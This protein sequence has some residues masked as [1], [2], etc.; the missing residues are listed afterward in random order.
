M[1]LGGFGGAPKFPRSVAYNY[2]FRYF[3]RT[4]NEEASDMVLATLREMAKGGMHDQ[5]G[6]GFHRYSVDARWFVPHFE[7][8]LYDQAQL[9]VSYLEAYQIRASGNMPMLPATSSSTFF[10]TCSIRAEDSIPRRMRT[11]SSIP[12]IR[13]RRVRERFMCGRMSN[14]RVC[15]AALSRVGFRFAT[16]WKRMAMCGKTRRRSLPEKTFSYQKHSIAETAAKFG[17]PEE[18]VR[19]ALDGAIAKLLKSRGKRVR[20][21]LDDKILTAWNG[22]MISAL[23]KGAA[24]LGEPRYFQA[25][26]NAERSCGNRCIGGGFC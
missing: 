20:P 22:L 6:G 5:L 26:R 1:K 9:A 3:Y 16:A 24:V 11:A 25:A 13:T 18:E 21:H 19:L 23:A 2:L 4:G 15:S 17:V 7:K 10:G 12:R 8:M 14:C